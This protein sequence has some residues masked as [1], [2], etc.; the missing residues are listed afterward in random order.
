MPFLGS[1]VHKLGYVP[2]EFRPSHEPHRSVIKTSV[3][4]QTVAQ[5]PGPGTPKKS[6]VIRTT[7]HA[8]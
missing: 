2:A 7:A 5:G 6:R 8:T 3:S 4:K 1:P